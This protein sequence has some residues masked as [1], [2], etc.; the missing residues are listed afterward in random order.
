ME[1][2]VVFHGLV[3]LGECVLQELALPQ[4]QLGG[5][6]DLVDVHP[7]VSRDCQPVA[8]GLLGQPVEEHFEET[9]HDVEALL[10][11]LQAGVDVGQNLSDGL[12][13]DQGLGLGI[14]ELALGFGLGIPPFPPIDNSGGTPWAQDETLSVGIGNHRRDLGDI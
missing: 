3:T 10:G 6:P 11:D 4:D 8:N 14:P 2:S 9:V 12:D 13:V 7:L 1:L 5:L